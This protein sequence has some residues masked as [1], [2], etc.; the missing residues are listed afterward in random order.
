[1]SSTGLR[2]SNGK[3]SLSAL[4]ITTYHVGKDE[5]VLQ[6]PGLFNCRFHPW[7]ISSTID[8]CRCFSKSNEDVFNLHVGIR[9]VT[10]RS[11]F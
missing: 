6:K 1:M 7:V 4:I 11:L 5:S 9:A 2:A 8:L 3:Q 10:D